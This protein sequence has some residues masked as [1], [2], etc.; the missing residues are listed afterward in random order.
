MNDKE[1]KLR[2]ALNEYF[3]SDVGDVKGC[4]IDPASPTDY[5]PE[6]PVD[7]TKQIT[8][9]TKQHVPTFA[10]RRKK[11]V[12][13]LNKELKEIDDNYSVVKGIASPDVT[14]IHYDARPYCELYPNGN[15]NFHGVY[16]SVK[17][18]TKVMKTISGF[19]WKLKRLKEQYK[20]ETI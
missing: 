9:L 5:I 8:I 12:D 15:I 11:L 18:M 10:E 13:Q 3:G 16:D 17:Q 7:H 14:Y 19:S 2:E 1:K 4:F 20:D 6:C